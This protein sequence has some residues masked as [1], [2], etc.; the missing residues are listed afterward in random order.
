M[1]LDELDKIDQLVLCI[2]NDPN[3]ELGNDGDKYWAHLEAKYGMG[4]FDMVV[5]TVN[6]F[7][8]LLNEKHKPNNVRQ[9][10]TT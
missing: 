2:L 9:Q 4:V 3:V 8:N 10:R 5:P 1:S 7:A 6:E